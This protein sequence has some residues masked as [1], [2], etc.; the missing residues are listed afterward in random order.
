[1]N[2]TNW[3]RQLGLDQYEP[4]F[5]ENDINGE[6][7]GSLTAD[8]LKELGVKSI[9]HRR[10]LLGQCSSLGRLVPTLSSMDTSILSR[11]PQGVSCA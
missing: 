11:V 10:K 3:L 9:G 8:D 5:R 6:L 7:L 1:M 4:A 2:I